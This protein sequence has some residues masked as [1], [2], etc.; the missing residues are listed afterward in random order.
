MLLQ[1]DFETNYLFF[2]KYFFGAK[3]STSFPETQPALKFVCGR[4][5]SMT[6]AGGILGLIN[7]ESSGIISIPAGGEATI[8]LPMIF[9][10]GS[11]SVSLSIGEVTSEVEGTQLL[12]FTQI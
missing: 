9:G 4:L 7:Y 10:I 2:L 5:I 11:I 1:V 8:S 12:I 6:A 3:R